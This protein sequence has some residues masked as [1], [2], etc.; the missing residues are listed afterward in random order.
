MANDFAFGFGFDAI[1]Q[2]L[3]FRIILNNLS[4]DMLK[5]REFLF[6]KFM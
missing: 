4:Y 1:F 6:F 3:N 2:F 5:R